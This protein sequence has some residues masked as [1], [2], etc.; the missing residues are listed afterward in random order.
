MMFLF[1]A[2]LLVAGS[3]AAQSQFGT[4]SGRVTDATG[5][6]VPQAKV[7]ITNIAT[8]TKDTA[9]S[10]DEGI[11][12][13]ANLPTGTYEITV[14]KTGFKKL[15]SKVTLAIAQRLD[16]DFKLELG[17]ITEVITVTEAALV[18]N[19]V[20]GELATEITGRD[21]E[22][23]PLLTRNP[24]NLVALAAGASDTG[25]VTGDTRGLGIAVFG[26]R[27][28]SVNFMLDGGENNDTFVAGLGQTVPLD[29]VQEMKVQTNS[30]TAEFGRNMIVT[31]VVTKGGTNDFHGSA[32]EYYRGAALSSSTF[33]DNAN[34]TPK[35]NFVR[36]QFGGSA[37][38]A[39]IKDKL[40]YFGS[41]EGQRVRSAASARFF[42]PTAAFMAASSANTTG[43][44]NAFGGAPASN[45]SD[46]AITAQQIVEDVEGG[47]PGSYAGAPLLDS[48]TLA[49]IPAATQLFCRTT[50]SQ[51]TDSG[52]GDPQNTW[53]ATGRIDW[54]VS[55]KTTFF[56]RYAFS[57]SKFFD[58]SVSFSPFEGFNTGQVNKNQNL[59][60]TLTHSFS[61]RL[62]N[63]TRAIYN[64]IFNLQPLGS[65]AA[66]TPCWQYDFFSNSP[67][68]DLI[69]FPG[70]V[71]DV[72]SF[73]GIP[74]GGPQN[75]YQTF[76]GFTY[77]LG[78]H[79]VKWGG[80][81]LHMRDNRSFG[82]YENA[83]FDSFSMQNMLDGVVDFIF[84]AVDPRGKTVGD[85]Y[86]PAA[87]PVGDGPYQ[88]PSFTRHFH[89]NELAFYVEDSWR[90][91]PRVT[92]TAGLRWEYFGVLHSP[93]NE[94]FLDANL[95]L[96]AVGSVPPLTGTK[97]VYESVRDARFRRTNQFYRP[98]YADFAPRIGLAWDVF[99]DGRTVARAG[100]GIYYD[101]NFG[102][103]VFN[104]IQN[105]PNYAVVSLGVSAPIDPNQFNTL[106]SAGATTISSSARMLNND[107]VTAYAQQW[108]ATI[109]H[110]ILGKGV[111]V[112]LSYIGTKGD[113]LYSLNNLN[114]RGSCLLLVSV[115]PGSPCDPVAVAG[116]ASRINQTGLTGMNRRGNEGMSRYHGMALEVKTRRLANTGLSIKSNYTW[117][118][119]LDNVSSFFADSTFEGLFG[120]G[121]RDPYNPAL[122]M[123]SSSND[124]R[125]RGT[126]SGVWEVP[127]GK[128]QAGFAR[129]ALYGWTLSGI[130]T[131]QTGGTFSV[132]DGSPASQCALSG[133]N[134]CFPILTGSSV[135]GITDTP[136]TGSPNQFVLYNLGSFYQTQAD[137]CAANSLN[138]PLGPLTGTGCTAVIANLRADLTS[139]RNLFRTPGIWNVDAGVYKDFF[140]PWEGHKLQLRAEFFN[141]FN[142]SNLYADAGTNV[143]VGGGADTVTAKRGVIPTY[144]NTYERRNIQVALRY[145]W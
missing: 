75:I 112:S 98:D 67:T 10:N 18:I 102:N 47:G 104:A 39:I 50:L 53:L 74:F 73:A 55:D 131:A 108:N 6:V 7:N 40:F 126:I 15:S 142:H 115:V 99:G 20:S 88:F 17:Q 37:G 84:A 28:S 113:K 85:T 81:F 64:R 129:Q 107:M 9:E 52:G 89:Y 111:L 72:C 35:A 36:N 134:F 130:F 49:P 19:T 70:Y 2:V 12:V 124:I 5:A 86:D 23:L 8:N 69:V 119:S 57:Y 117:S 22:N 78:K 83:Y 82:A 128:D 100:Y 87:P 116:N 137:Y 95:Y 94:R 101:R 38:G 136:V 29:A 31:N 91:T 103:A 24:Y 93:E 58:G 68:G 105:P 141:L 25:S 3:V 133:T 14:E 106:A 66:T 45:C 127:F 138:S 80:Q 51:P 60:L 46:Q 140:L 122:D 41:I 120:F 27:T 118:H 56:G 114:Q 11:F 63:E 4:I 132:Y 54:R 16:L 135:P 62:F 145:T 43:F 48:N 143:F 59:N 65:A 125:H 92:L 1:L 33:D 44:I 110:D 26:A 30:T 121:F 97:S 77:S 21:L 109:E 123:A 96:D 34:G 61:P 71:P 144:P 79:T 42:V 13:L 76:S 32:Y 90:V 139:P